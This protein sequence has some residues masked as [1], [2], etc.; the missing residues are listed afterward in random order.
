MNKKTSI[1]LVDDEIAITDNLD[2]FLV[3]SGY[4][5]TV[6]NNG[7]EAIQKMH[8]RPPDLI[9]LDV[10]MPRLDGREVLRRIRQAGNWTPIILLTQVG[11][12]S[13]RA[14]A[15]EEGADDYLNKPFDP[16][17][18]VARIRAVLRRS[19]PGRPPLTVAYRLACGKLLIDRTSHRVWLGEGE[20]S[21]TPKSVMLLEYLMT[22]PDELVSRERLLDVVW[23]WDYPVG[24]RAVDT[25]VAELRR[26][27]EDDPAHPCY[28]ETV[29]G[30]GYR[31]VG[32]VEVPLRSVG[33]G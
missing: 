8:V 2:S 26:A 18:L 22:H 15:L 13:E 20:L 14:M 25:R 9:V 33:A 5:V 31:F 10:L 6:A 16:H 23:G 28:I 7:E 17:E 1:L 21:L 12:A 19:L 11:E 30:Q 3:R 32:L 24:T 27:L 29:P 4:E